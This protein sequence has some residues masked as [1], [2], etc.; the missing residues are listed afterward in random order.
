MVISKYALDKKAFYLNTVLDF[1]LKVL[2]F[3]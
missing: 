2:H 1:F 3:G